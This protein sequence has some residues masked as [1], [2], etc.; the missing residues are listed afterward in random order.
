MKKLIYLFL[1]SITLILHS[2]EKSI[3]T[4]MKIEAY[5]F[6]SLDQ[7][8]GNWKTILLSSNEQIEL[9]AP[10]DPNSPEIKAAIDEVVNKHN[11]N[12][13][14]IQYWGINPLLRWNELAREL[15]AKYNLPPAPN[16]DGIFI[17]PSPTNP[18]SYPYFP[19]AHPP[20]AS[21]AFAY[22]SIAQY[23][24]LVLA[25][26]YK[27]KYNQPALHKLD[28]RVKTVFEATDL[29]SYPCDGAVI[30]AVNESLLS[31]FFPLEVEFIKAKAT[32]M[33]NCLIASG[34]N[35]KED[36]EAGEFLGREVAKIF[37]QR[38]S[39]DGMNVAQAPRPVSDSL[40]NIAK[41]RFGWQWENL[42]SPKRPV[43]ITPLFGKVKP[44]FV[45]NITV[46]RPGPPPA[47]GS[48]EFNIAA[49]ELKNIQ[50][51]L[52]KEQRK[53]ANWWSDGPTTY[54]PP[55]H[56]NRLAVNKIVENKYNPLRSARVLA[57]MNG[58]I[59]D[60]GI[61]CW[62]TK[63]Y[64][65]YPRPINAIP[66]FK[67]ILGTPNFPAYTSGH[68]TFSSAAAT[69][70]SAIFPS[71]SK[72]FE[73]WALEASDSRVYGGIHFRFDCVQGL[74]QGRNVAQFAVVV[75]TRDGAN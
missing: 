18:G 28:N 73:D 2:C 25:W 48:P 31:V 43:G 63:Y 34:I 62:D 52:T 33:K 37:L 68:S 26:H 10:K 44:W 55:G 42:E 32:E 58:A 41:S 49:D 60:A 3:E 6:S 64:Y 40:A 71:D 59:Q 15:A 14:A 19:F 9:P 65:N 29:P 46:L 24:A 5:N 45:P 30:A 17:L 57:Y 70:L 53:I 39:T 69:V 36:I 13:D 20:Y 75:A 12:P 74:I 51:N 54:T 61:S 11:E 23:D 35:S 66:R 8:G 27:Y 67:T 1:I 4:G 47:I 22:L 50:A 7:N 72:Q 16:A 38:A 56:W 21:R